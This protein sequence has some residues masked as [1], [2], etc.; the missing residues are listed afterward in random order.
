MTKH[1]MTGPTETVSFVP[2]RHSMFPSVSPGGTLGV[3]GK[4]NSLFPLEPV[5]IGTLK[6]FKAWV[7]GF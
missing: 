1:L 2:P 4:Q 3:S 7:K 5:V 6:Q